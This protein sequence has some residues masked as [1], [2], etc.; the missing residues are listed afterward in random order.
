MNEAQ[1]AERE[2]IV[3]AYSG[4]PPALVVL[5]AVLLMLKALAPFVVSRI[6]WVEAGCGTSCTDW[7]SLVPLFAKITGAGLLVSLLCAVGIWRGNRAGWLLAPVLVRTKN[8][9]LLLDRMR[10]TVTG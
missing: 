5:Y 6:A 3:A 8:G 9:T 10:F 2:R 7:N 4:G 1:R